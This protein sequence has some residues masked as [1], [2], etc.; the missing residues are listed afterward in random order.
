MI[1]IRKWSETFEVAKTRKLVH[2]SWINVPTGVDSSGYLALM[3]RG[4][5]G[6]AAL[7]V[8]TAICQWS[9]TCRPAIRGTL[10]RSDGA[11]LKLSQLA[12]ILR[13]PQEIVTGAVAVL[14][15]PDVA[16]LEEISSDKPSENE[17][18][19][20]HPPTVRHSSANHLPTV[21]VQG[22]EGSGR[23]GN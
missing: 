20:N 10:A 18:S 13:M 16:W 1:R 14:L 6:V 15:S 19:A 21:R 17:Q 23:E 22:R 2:L 7:G 12:M 9:A 8:F 3:E 5:D 11:P 4:A